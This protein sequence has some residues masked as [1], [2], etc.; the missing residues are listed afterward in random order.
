MAKKITYKAD[1][2]LVSLL[3][4]ALLILP[5]IFSFCQHN[6]E[7][8]AGS[9]NREKAPLP[10][11]DWKH[12]DRFPQQFNDF[13]DDHF[14]LRPV[15]VKLYNRFNYFFLKQSPDA[16]K[17]ILGKN[18]WMF[19]GK[20]LDYYRVLVRLS[21]EQQIALKNEFQ[22]RADF[23]HRRGCRFLLVIVPTKKEIYTEYV[24][25]EFFKYSRENATDQILQLAKEVSN[26]DVIDLKPVLIKSKA[27]YPEVYHR[28][29][30]HWNDYGAYV[31]YDTIISYLQQHMKTTQKHLVDEFTE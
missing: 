28:Y 14:S 22:R 7:P 9:E 23:L 31:A 21:T 12:L 6:D 13:Y 25:S 26:L 3:F 15:G 24:P 17:G 27:I 29:D 2:L 5:F 20:D 16:S 4:T 1:Q 30:H 18:N 11:F 8:M 10:V 19:Q